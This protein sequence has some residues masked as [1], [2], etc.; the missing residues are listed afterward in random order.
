MSPIYS[1]G[2]I[3]GAEDQ[4][5]AN[6]GA[7]PNTFSHILTILFAMYGVFMTAILVSYCVKPRS[8]GFHLYENPT[9]GQDL[10][11]PVAKLEVQW[12]KAFMAKVY[13]IMGLQLGITVLI[14]VSMMMFGGLEYLIWEHNNGLVIYKTAM[15][16]TFVSLIS[17]FCCCRKKFPLNMIMLT[18][19][20][21]SMSYVVGIVC[22]QYYV[23]GIGYIVAEAFALT[24]LIF[25]M[26]TIYAL[27]TKVD[28]NYLSLA[29]FTVMM[30]MF[31]W[32]ILCFFCFPTF[33][34][35]QVYC[36]LGVVL[37]ALLIVYDTKLNQE[38]LSYDEYVL[39]AVN[40]YLDFINMFLFILN[41][42]SGG[43]E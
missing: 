41:L 25:I 13:S 1:E 2:Q 23:M 16:T 6:S 37:M 14:S 17:L 28:M 31:W 40:L 24:S 9:S 10:S 35:Y 7:G 33:S 38:F 43:R 4:A 8:F 11:G 21:V 15:V 22:L 36:V 29:L 18:V 26:L 20:T 3:A 5:F 30:V 39:G 12:R 32:F 42:L 19:F 34:F 27:Q